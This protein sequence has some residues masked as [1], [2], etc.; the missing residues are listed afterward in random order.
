MSVTCICKNL[1]VKRGRAFD[2]SGCII[3]YIYRNDNIKFATTRI[4]RVIC[5]VHEGMYMGMESPIPPKV[6]GDGVPISMYT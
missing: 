1:G 5:I 3:V 6:Y 4:A 2:H